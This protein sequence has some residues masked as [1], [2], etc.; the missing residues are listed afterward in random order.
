MTRQR[1]LLINFYNIF[2]PFEVRV[3]MNNYS[4]LLN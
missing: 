4:F 3:K 1:L 2:Y